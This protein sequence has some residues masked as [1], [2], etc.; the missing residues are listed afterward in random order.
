MA[1][2]LGIGI[3]PG[4]KK[5]LFDFAA[6]ASGLAVRSLPYRCQDCGAESVFD[7]M[8]VSCRCSEDGAASPAPAISADPGSMGPNQG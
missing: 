2:G 4:T 5:G 1:T 6:L 8:I 3:N 7:S